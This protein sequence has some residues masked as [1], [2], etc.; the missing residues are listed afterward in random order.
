MSKSIQWNPKADRY[1]TPLQRDAIERGEQPRR[2]EGSVFPDET[3]NVWFRSGEHMKIV[4]SV[5][6]PRAQKR[7]S[8]ELDAP[9]VLPE[10]SRKTKPRA[11]KTKRK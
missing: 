1:L 5:D 6:A 3:G 4:G 8:G 7:A 9:S 11:R 10:A 2:L